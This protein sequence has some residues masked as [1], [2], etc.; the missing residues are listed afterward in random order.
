MSEPQPATGSR[1]PAIAGIL[2]VV[3]AAAGLYS[4]LNSEPAAPVL[5]LEQ[6]YLQ[7]R[8]VSTLVYDCQFGRTFDADT[9]DL[10]PV[11]I[12]KLNLGQRGPLRSY[13][14]ELATVGAPAIPGLRRLFDDAY[15]DKWRSGVLENVLAVCAL[16]DIDDGAELARLAI[17]HPNSNVRLAALDTLASHGTVEDYDLI[18]PWLSR[19][20]SEQEL[21]DY[22][23]TLA[24]VDGPRFY[25]DWL[26]MMRE[27]RFKPI[28]LLIGTRV[29]TVYDPE[30]VAGMADFAMS[31]DLNGSVLPFLL[32]P[33]ARDGDQVAHAFLIERLKSEVPTR[34]QFTLEAL[35]RVGFGVDAGPVLVESENPAL[36]K[37][38]AEILTQAEPTERVRGYLDQGLS[39]PDPNVRGV[40]MTA[41]IRMGDELSQSQAVALLGGTILERRRGIDALAGAVAQTPFSSADGGMRVTDDLNI[42]EYVDGA[43]EGADLEETELV[44]QSGLGWAGDA[45]LAQRVFEVLT[46]EY[47]QSPG[48]AQRI[49]ILKALGRVPITAAGNFVLDAAPDLGESVGSHHSLRW[50]AGQVYNSGEAGRALLRERLSTESAPFRRMDLIAFVWQDRSEASLEI[51]LEILEAPGTHPFERLYVADRLTRMRASSRVAGAIKRA[52]LACTHPEVR[53]ALQ[54]LLWTWYGQHNA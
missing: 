16:M 29:H 14:E 52:Y 46:A 49:S 10:V 34:V 3:L 26:G 31:P 20:T 53:P 27:G 18:Y 43:P 35:R 1:G 22:L 33:A 39:D 12:S 7:D 42:P 8:R 44:L 50:C 13:K 30:V 40:C 11:M 45:A 37:L 15:G 38:A 6:R 19:V 36:R 47:A 24:M 21:G 5:T 9:S 54:C 17:Q 32:G 4:R 41:L 28:W 51:L 23:R 2:V 25:R 48:R